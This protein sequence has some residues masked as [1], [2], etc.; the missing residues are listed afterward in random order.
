MDLGVSLEVVGSD[1]N[2]TPL[3]NIARRYVP[4]SDQVSKPRGSE[5]VYLV[6]VSWHQISPLS[7]SSCASL[8]RTLRSSIAF[9]SFFT[10]A[11]TCLARLG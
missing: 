4:G 1:I 11:S 6:V 7:L 2:N 3:I 10:I 9:L 8:A 5:R